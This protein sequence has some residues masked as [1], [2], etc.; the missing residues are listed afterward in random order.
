MQLTRLN[1]RRERGDLIVIYKWK[2][3]L[4]NM[5]MKKVKLISAHIM[6]K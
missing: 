3:N 5:E 1:G 4:E 2:N 6:A